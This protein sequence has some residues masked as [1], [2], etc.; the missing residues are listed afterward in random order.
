MKHTEKINATECLCSYLLLVWKKKIPAFA[1][2]R[3][4]LWLLLNKALTSSPLTEKL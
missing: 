2:K 1:I 3:I 4:F